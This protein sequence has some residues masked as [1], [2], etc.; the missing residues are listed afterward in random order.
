[1]EIAISFQTAYHAMERSGSSNIKMKHFK[2]GGSTWFDTSIHQGYG[3][4]RFSYI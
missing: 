4:L 2:A 1:M 3:N